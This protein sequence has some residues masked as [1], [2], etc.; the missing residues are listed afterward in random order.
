MDWIV[1]ENNICIKESY[2]ASKKSFGSILASI[3]ATN[4]NCNVFKR[5]MFS[6]KTEWATHN[7]LWYL[8]ILRARTADTDLNYPQ[9]WWEKIGYSVVGVIVWPFIP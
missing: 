6:L 4:P 7:A 5:S 8:H 1:T 3:R 9:K 2:K